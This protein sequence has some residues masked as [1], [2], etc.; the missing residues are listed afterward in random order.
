MRARK[1][2]L[3]TTSICG[4]ML[5]G[6]ACLS[7]T[8]KPG[9]GKYHKLLNLF[10]LPSVDTT[11]V[12]CGTSI[13]LNTVPV[14][15]YNS[16]VWSTGETGNSIT[17]TSPGDYSWYTTGGTIVTNGDFSASISTQAS[18]GF[19]SDYTYLDTSSPSGG[20]CGIL[21][22]EGAYVVGK[23]PHTY[24]TNFDSFGDHTTGTGRMLIVNGASVPNVTV[25]AQNINVMPNT[26]YIFSVW[27]TSVNPVSPAILSFSING[28]QQ[29]GTVSLSSAVADGTW[30][31]FTTVWNSGTTSGTVPIAL[32]NQNT[33][34]NG[35][36]FAV[37]DI[38]F[39]PIVK[40]T[41]HVS[42]NQTPVLAL[43]GPHETC[44][45]YDLTSAIVGYDPA[46]YFYFFTD[47][48]G[49]TVTSPQAITHS[50]VYTI[51]EQ[52]KVTGCSSLPQQTTITIDPNPAKPNITSL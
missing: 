51:T 33:A 14:A 21:S 35:N 28:T 41:I 43:N 10:A 3:K 8:G 39:A 22:G 32:V 46:T 27:A 17:V 49:T 29:I 52:N 45:T 7:F 13:V 23:N 4:F 11:V 2:P 5:L 48:S 34:A 50:G 9:Q 24:H 30:Q 40:Q 20:C 18:R 6:F 19:T 37:D 44:G 12:A 42:F 16:P 25:W 1:F 31:Y 15:G 26:D 47:S 36:D 38:V